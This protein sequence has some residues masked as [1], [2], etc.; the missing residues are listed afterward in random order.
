MENYFLDKTWLT[1][2][3]INAMQTYYGMAIRQNVNSLYQM[4]KAVIAILFH[5]SDNVNMEERHK[6]CPRVAESWCKFQ[7][8]NITNNRT[9]R[10]NTTQFLWLSNMN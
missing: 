5:C 3:I 1:K 7:A 10:P 8:D 2:K 4:K 9:Y 6:F